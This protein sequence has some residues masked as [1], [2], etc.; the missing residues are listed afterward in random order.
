MKSWTGP[1][2]E[3]KSSPGSNSQSVSDSVGITSSCSLLAYPFPVSL[4]SL[5]LCYLCFSYLEL[6]TVLDYS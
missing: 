6:V 3:A 2:N 4:T 5:R 1:W